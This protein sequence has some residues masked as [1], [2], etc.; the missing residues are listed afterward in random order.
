MLILNVTYTR[1][2]AGV[3]FFQPTDV[4]P[5]WKEL[6]NSFKESG[7]LISTETTLDGEPVVEVVEGNG[8]LVMVITSTWRSVAENA[9]FLSLPESDNVRDARIAYCLE[10]GIKVEYNRTVVNDEFDPA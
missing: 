3:K 2:T 10:H 1:P 6:I 8:A 4:V 7:K 5:N 9:E